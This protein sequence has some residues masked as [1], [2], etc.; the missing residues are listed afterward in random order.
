MDSR[1]YKGY[2][3]LPSISD[4]QVSGLLTIESDGHIVLELFGAF[5]LEERGLSFDADFESVIWGRCYDENN[6]MTDISLFNCNSA[7]TLNFSSTFPLTRY[8]CRYAFIGFHGSSIDE[9]LFF[10][11]SIDFDEL[12]HWCPPHNV[13]MTCYK[14]KISFAV[15]ILR[16]SDSVIASVDFN[17]GMQLNLIKGIACFPEYPETVIKQS[18][19]LEVCKEAFS[20]NYALLQARNFERFLSVAILKPVEHG[21]IRLFS[22]D[23]CQ[24]PG[25]TPIYHPIEMIVPLYQPLQSLTIKRPYDFL[26]DFPKIEAEFNSLYTRFCSDKNISQIWDNLIVSLEKRRIY[27]SHDFLNV[28]QALDGFSIRYRR[29]NG[30]EKQLISLRDEFLGI[31]KMTLTDADLKAAT[32]SRHYYSHILKLEKKQDKSALDGIELYNL[33]KKLRVLLFCCVLNFLGLSN[34]RIN[35]ML[36]SCNAPIVRC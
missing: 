29:E 21:T 35:E 23:C 5:A 15:D 25:E 33:T 12:V 28:I 3:W 34:D 6:H 1:V 13:Q 24:M 22:R 30:F 2:W 32:G 19:Y 4:D 7:I 36:N 26:F 17:D 27:S 11:A 14:D 20:A 18:T 9:Q 31:D 10:K 16:N 8:T